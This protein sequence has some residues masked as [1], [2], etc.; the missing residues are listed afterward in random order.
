MKLEH[1]LPG[2]LRSSLVPKITLNQI[3]Y[4]AI[5]IN[6]MIFYTGGAL[7]EKNL[8]FLAIFNMIALTLGILLRPLPEK[9]DE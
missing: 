1:V 5:L 9:D 4:G 3:S 6:M 8:Q 7:Y 2:L